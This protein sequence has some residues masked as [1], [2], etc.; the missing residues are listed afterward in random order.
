M[1][2]EISSERNSI[3]VLSDDYLNYIYSKVEDDGSS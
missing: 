1:K 2:D 3:E